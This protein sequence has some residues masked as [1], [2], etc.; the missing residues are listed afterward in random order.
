MNKFPEGFLWGSATASHQVEGNT[1]NNWSEW[2]KKNAERLAKEAENRPTWQ[3]NKFPEMLTSENYIS[4]K[5]SDHYHLY[6]SDFDLLREGQQKAYRFS[7]EWSRIEP[8][9]GK[10][11]QN[12]VEH[13]KKVLQ[14][15]RERGIEPFVTMWHWTHPVWLEE[16]G[17]SESRKF[18]FY[19]SRYAGYLA[20][21][22]GDQVN[23]W[24]TLNEPDVVSSHAFLKGVWPPQKKNMFSFLRAV[25]NLAEAHRLT[26]GSVKEKFPKAKIGVAKHQVAFQVLRP[27]IINNILKKLGDYFWNDW[28]LNKIKNYQ[29][30]IGLNHY[31]RNVIDNGFYKNPNEKLTDFGWEFYPESIYQALDE[32]KKYNKPIYI[33]EN[34]I[35]DAADSMREEFLERSLASVQQA[36]SEG[37]DVRGY[38]YWSLLDNFE[39][40]KGYWPRFGLIEID[41]KTLERKPRKSFYAYRDIIKNNGVE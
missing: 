37:V 16:K 8:E 7:I 13:Y 21:H 27:T 5:S 4:G 10:F 35:A 25:N 28:F 38:F 36:I 32:L 40:D 18:P 11:D 31:N 22:L 23:F 33:T 15:L 2:E 19:F 41:Y 1:F 29:D 34:G 20:E 6:E 3:K 17:G 14:S 24:I 39:W 9:E 26:F 30:F 12:E